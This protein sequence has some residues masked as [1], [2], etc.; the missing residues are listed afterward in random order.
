MAKKILVVEDD[1]DSRFIISAQVRLIGYEPIEAA[2][3]TDAIEKAVAEPPGLILMDLAMPGMTGIDAAKTLKENPITAHIPIVAYTAWDGDDW[4]AP[5]LEAGMAHYLVKPVM[6]E[7][8]KAT[9]AKFI[10]SYG[11]AGE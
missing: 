11:D 3:A 4:R 2:S 6:P 1:R 7:R 8:L 10:L 5:A 9:I